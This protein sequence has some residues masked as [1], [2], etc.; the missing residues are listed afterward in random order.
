[1]KPQPIT[2]PATLDV[3]VRPLGENDLPEAKRIFHVA[4]GTFLGLPNPMEFYPDRDYV[5]TRYAADPSAALG[6]E[7]EG[8][9]VGSNFATNWGSVG[10]FG[11]LTIR[12]DYWD[13]GIAKRLLEPTMEIFEKWGTKHAGLFTFGH[14]AKHVGLYQKFGFWP[15]FL[16]AIMSVKVGRSADVQG[17]TR[18]SELSE[19][20]RAE[21]QR[22]AAELTNAIYDGL[23]VGSEIRAVAAQ[24][25][26]DT[27][28]LSDR[29]ALAGL[30]LCHCGSDTE[31]GNDTCYIKFAAVRPGKKA[32][33]MFERLLDA[34]DLFAASRRLKRIEA[35]V[36]L[37][38]QEAYQQM[39][40]HGFRT[41]FQ[42]VTMHKPNESGYSRSGV[43]VVDD[44]R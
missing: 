42:G 16:T 37:A 24:E 7:V 17:W 43:Y 25:L 27:V 41:A 2:A 1:M 15:R 12:P 13:R 10:F 3:R 11:P 6:A 32:A 38:R 21:C 4:F 29:S 14:S 19:A 18:Y 36:N 35:G 28:L 20:G 5:R 30:A 40:A 8:E 23:D 31:A 39:L 44:W 22:A 34:C 33:Q 26:G 9:L